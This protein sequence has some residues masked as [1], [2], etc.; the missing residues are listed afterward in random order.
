MVTFTEMLVN[1]GA[2]LL[3][4]EKSKDNGTMVI[5]MVGNMRSGHTGQI[6]TAAHHPGDDSVPRNVVHLGIFFRRPFPTPEETNIG[7]LHMRDPKS[8]TCVAST[9]SG[10]VV[11]SYPE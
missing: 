11:I 2:C 4:D 3:V 5:T 6:S 7:H 10:R 8:P 9:W 1:D